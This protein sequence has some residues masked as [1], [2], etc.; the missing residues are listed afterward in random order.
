MM[1]GDPTTLSAVQAA[2]A[3]R[4]GR[5]TSEALV[6]A[7]LKKI[8]AT[9]GTLKAWAHLDPDRAL[10]RAREMD[11]VRKA[12]L[13]VGP[14]Q[15]L[16]VA[17]K[18]IVDTRDYQT[19]CGAQAFA[20][21]RPDRDAAIVERLTEAGAVILGKTKTT[22]FA[23]VHP[24]DTVN[25]HDPAR[26][27]GGSSS[28]SAAAVA[29]GHVPLAIG[30][31][32]GGSVIRPASYC[33][34]Y[35]F[36]PTRGMISR[37]GVLQTSASLDHIGVFA[38]TLEDAALLTGAIASYDPADAA[39]IDR[40]RPDF[41]GG[42]RA[43]PPVDPD[44]AWFDFPFNDRMDPDARAGMDAVIETLGARVTRLPVAQT[45]TDLI[46]VHLD[47][48]EYEFCRHMAEVIDAHWDSLSATLKPV[49]ERGRAISD[50]QYQDALGVKASAEAFFA[51]HFE[52][53]DAILCPSATGEPPLI[54][55]GSTGDPVFCRIWSLCGLPSLSLP[56]LVGENG[57]PIGVQL[58][59][60]FEKD[61]RLFRTAAWMQ[62]RLAAEAAA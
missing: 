26:S 21:R 6:T 48:H 16:P 37:R 35:G 19:E 31:Q 27:P 56:V 44:I 7:C 57:L 55:S 41:L 22:E 38:R 17:L 20:G 42:A 12:G 36:K 28:G 10:A 54:A 58:V 46:D 43:E 5:L 51:R 8:E 39:S 4:A 34:I 3:I 61:D 45:L 11:R 2:D 25:P 24:T 9:D 30:S 62:H 52:D 14:L 15:G 13:G 18:D 50:T 1:K 33:G 49:V 53:F 40:A 59:G 23:F 32:T 47:I 60:S 29:A